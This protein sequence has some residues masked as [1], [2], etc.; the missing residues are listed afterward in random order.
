MVRTHGAPPHRPRQNPRPRRQERSRDDHLE[1]PHRQPWRD[2]R[3]RRP[4]LPRRRHRVVA[5]YADPTATRCTC[6]VADEAYALGGTTPGETYLVVDKV[7]DVA[8]EVRRRRGA[9]RLRLPVRERR[10]RAGRHRRRPRPGSA[11]RRHAIRALGD[12]VD[13]PAHRA[14]V[15]A[16]LVAGTADP[17][18]GADE[19]VAFAA[20]ARPAGRHQGG[21]RRRRPRPQG[22]PHASR[23]SPS[24]SSPRSARRSP[25]SAAASASSSA[26]STSRATSRPR[27]LADQHGNVVVVVD[28][29]LLAAAPPPEAGRGGARA[30]PHRGAARAALHARRRRSSRR[31]ATSA[32]APASS[33]SARTAPSPSSRSTPACRSST[34]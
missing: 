29:R 24:C 19:V 15:G 11:R 33:S 23:R 4:G 10:V 20:R 6:S 21:L 8:R 31:P 34:P 7:L 2:R 13:G 32:P 25:P 14:E 22:R 26:T 1:G 30:V 27:C 3:P 12:K 9:P 5:V 16:P 28:A 17:V 18:E